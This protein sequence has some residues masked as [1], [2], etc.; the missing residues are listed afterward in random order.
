MPR[1]SDR[2]GRNESVAGIISRNPRESVGVFV[3]GGAF[4]IICA[5]ALFFQPGPHPAPIFASKPASKLLARPPIALPPPAPVQR[6]ETPVRPR[7]QIIA[8]IQRELARRSFY[9]GAV[10]GVWGAKTDAAARDF[11]QANRLKAPVEASEDLLRAIAATAVA[12]KAATQTES[13]RND[14]IAQLLAPDRRILAVQN[15][16]AAYGYGQISPS[17]TLDSQTHEAIRKFE[18]SHKMPVTGQISDQL[19]RALSEMS[20]RPID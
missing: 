12:G 7:A 13:V 4:A 17:G 20:G 8:D 18:A 2:S 10:D 3:A 19:V 14:P 6:V 5:N 15:V 1:R 16:L 9:D 11:A